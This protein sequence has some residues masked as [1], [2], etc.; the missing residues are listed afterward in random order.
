MVGGNTLL[1]SFHYLSKN[2]FKADTDS[3]LLRQKKKNCSKKLTNYEYSLVMLSK[4]LLQCKHL[5][6]HCHISQNKLFKVS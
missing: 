2:F 4:S 3:L 6:K 1:F 5:F